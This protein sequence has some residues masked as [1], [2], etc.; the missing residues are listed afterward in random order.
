MLLK[1]DEIL[2]RIG[3]C[4]ASLGS[5]YSWGIY[6]GQGYLFINMPI[7]CYILIFVSVDIFTIV[8]LI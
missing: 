3:T 5:A 8:K 4:F 1:E 7:V 6:C 2:N